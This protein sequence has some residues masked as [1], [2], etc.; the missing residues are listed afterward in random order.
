VL[1]VDVLLKEI[2]VEVEIGAV[3]PL[4]Y[5][6]L[7]ELVEEDSEMLLIEGTCLGTKDEDRCLQGYFSL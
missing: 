2:A 6:F 5:A 7:Q 4:L 3:C 1:Q